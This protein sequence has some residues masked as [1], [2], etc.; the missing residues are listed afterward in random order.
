MLVNE[1]SKKERHSAHQTQWAAQFAVASELCKR[2]YEVGFTMGNHP[3]IDLMVVSPKGVNFLVDV[4]G[5]YKPNFWPV[6]P[7]MTRDKLFYVLAFVPENVL[8]Q[9]FILTQDQVNQGIR[10]DL[11]HARSLRKAKG[12]SGDPADF[13]GIQR[14]FAQGFEDAWKVLPK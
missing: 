10:I 2:G 9:F 11:E 3:A 8:N 7:K 1:Q 14:K 12:L 6:R 5:Q 13:P 4:K